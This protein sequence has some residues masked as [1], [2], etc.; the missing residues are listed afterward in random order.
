M[1]SQ[2]NEAHLVKSA[3]H[4][5][6]HACSTSG[7]ADRSKSSACEIQVNWRSDIW[8]EH[9]LYARA[10]DPIDK[11]L[12]RG[13][14]RTKQ[15]QPI[16]RN[17]V[18]TGP[19][20]EKTWAS[21]FR[22][23]YGSWQH[24]HRDWSYTFWNDSATG[25]TPPMDN[26]NMEAFVQRFFPFFLPAWRR[27]CHRVMKFDVARYMWLYVYG[28][29][30]D[31]RAWSVHTILSISTVGDLNPF[32]RSK[33]PPQPES[34]SS[35]HDCLSHLAPFVSTLFAGLY[36]DLDVAAVRSFAP[37][38]DGARL[39][40]VGDD[41]RHT[42]RLNCS[43]VGWSRATAAG[44]DLSTSDS[45]GSKDTTLQTQDCGPHFGNY[46][47]AAEPRHPLFMLLLR[48]VA[49]NVE[50]VCSRFETQMKP[51]ERATA[52][53]ELTGPLALGRNFLVWC[54]FAS[55]LQP[56]SHVTGARAHIPAH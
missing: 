48:Y 32:H 7:V 1:L 2:A 30:C 54:R 45:F 42:S 36:V 26:P 29:A 44:T 51:R 31:N 17:I 55:Q 38:L 27:L 43:A 49:D 19:P 41:T 50:D 5:F 40:L 11:V 56:L 6:Q 4:L 39:V 12:D 33:L 9:P 16:P 21:A 13:W 22:D 25:G 10:V 53:L 18:Q 23:S 8:R 52:V 20:N 28:G 35:S 37:L 14:K 24:W 47:M 34:T 15:P 3:A 46:L